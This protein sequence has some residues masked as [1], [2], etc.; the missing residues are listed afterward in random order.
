MTAELIHRIL[1]ED[2]IAI[3]IGDAG[4]LALTCEHLCRWLRDASH[5]VVDSLHSFG[6]TDVE[7]LIETLDRLTGA[8]SRAFPSVSPHRLTGS[9][10]LCPAETLSL[11]EFLLDIANDLRTEDGPEVQTLH[12]DCR[13][14][15]LRLAHTPGLRP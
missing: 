12:D 6:G 7:A 1:N 14:W 3:D 2:L 13:R 15:A 4:E 10:A 11:A 9:A 8:L 5:P